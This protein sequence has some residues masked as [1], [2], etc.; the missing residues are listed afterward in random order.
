MRWSRKSGPL[1]CSLVPP[2]ACHAVD[3]RVTRSLKHRWNHVD[4]R[5][6]VV[7]ERL[8]TC[9]VA[10]R[11]NRVPLV[12]CL[13]PVDLQWAP[14]AYSPHV[15]KLPTCQLLHSMNPT[16]G[17]PYK[18]EVFRHDEGE[19]EGGELERGRRVR[20][21]HVQ[22][23]GACARRALTRSFPLVVPSSCSPTLT[24]FKAK[25]RFR[26]RSCIE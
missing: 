13:S 6:S 25:H 10:L 12:P 3:A 1:P 22:S 26:I 7:R 8:N 9:F 16:F 5:Y 21:G 23:G 15:C 20:I 19:R 17:V 14:L 11:S 18:L 2:V 4:M 24:S